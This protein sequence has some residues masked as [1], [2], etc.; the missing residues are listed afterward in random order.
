MKIPDRP[1]KMVHQ[2]M[3]EA[4]DREFPNRTNALDFYSHSTI[5]DNK[6]FK[7]IMKLVAFYID[8]NEKMYL[9]TVKR[10]LRW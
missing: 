3:I 6:G 4:A 9:G 7:T 1:K 5:D 2:L 8:K 10:F